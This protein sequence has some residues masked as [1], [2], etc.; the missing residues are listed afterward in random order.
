[1]DHRESY[2]EAFSG[3]RAPAEEIAEELFRF[4]IQVKRHIDMK[5]PII[6]DTWSNQA[7]VLH[8]DGAGDLAEEKWG[9]EVYIWD[10]SRPNLGEMFVVL[11]KNGSQNIA[12][13]DVLPDPNGPA[14]TF[15]FTSYS[16]SA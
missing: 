12:A 1:M 3:Q 4:Q 6:Y 11:G 5:L 14:H 13:R 9:A 7:V 10:E 15:P 2:P 16:V 8:F